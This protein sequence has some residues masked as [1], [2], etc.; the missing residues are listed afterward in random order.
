[1]TLGEFVRLPAAEREKIYQAI[2]PKVWTEMDRKI[3]EWKKQ[4]VMKPKD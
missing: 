3:A 4:L 1:M 2:M